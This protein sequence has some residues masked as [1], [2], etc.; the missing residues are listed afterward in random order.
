MHTLLLAAQTVVVDSSSA[1]DAVKYAAMAASFVLALM[2]LLDV[3]RP[4]WSVGGVLPAKLQPLA[5]ALV[6]VLPDLATGLTNVKTKQD[7]LVVV[8]AF[9]AAFQGAMRGQ[10]P[11]NQLAALPKEVHADLAKVQKRKR[12]KV[13]PLAAAMLG[14]FLLTGCAALGAATKVLSEVALVAADAQNAISTAQAIADDFYRVMPAPEKQ[15]AVN[16]ALQATR[17]A[18]AASNEL[19]KAAQEDAAKANKAYDGF[20]DAYNALKRT[21]AAYGVGLKPGARSGALLREPM[22]MKPLGKP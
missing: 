22:A 16:A 13:A 18:L 20:R 5:I 17:D 19:A 15:E 6:S 2:R 11:D 10:L 8:V 4:L 21:F 9:I 3:G 7:I 14:V 1:F 12:I